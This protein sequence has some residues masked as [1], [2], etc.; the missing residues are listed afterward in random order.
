ME[1]LELDAVCRGQKAAPVTGEK[2]HNTK[3]ER[4]TH[5]LLA[6]TFKQGHL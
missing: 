6:F 5:C 4:R 2:Q 3:A 1:I